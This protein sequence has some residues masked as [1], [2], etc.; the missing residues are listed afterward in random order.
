M[1]VKK[2]PLDSTAWNGKNEKDDSSVTMDKDELLRSAILSLAEHN[3]QMMMLEKQL[4]QELDTNKALQS[5]LSQTENALRSREHSL[6]TAQQHTRN[7]EDQVLQLNLALNNRVKTEAV[8]PPP[9]VILDTDYQELQRMLDSNTELSKA[10]EVVFRSAC[11]SADWEKS[12]LSRFYLNDSRAQPL[13]VVILELVKRGVSPTKV[14]TLVHADH[15]DG[16]RM[17]AVL[18]SAV[19]RRDMTLLRSQPNYPMY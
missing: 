10:L 13:P 8:S 17:H 1:S 5:R 2:E 4:Q 6:I 7:L 16:L 11:G 15:P 3:Q 19:Y 18:E 12:F 14:S 9:K